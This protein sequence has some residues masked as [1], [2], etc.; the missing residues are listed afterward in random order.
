MS[1]DDFHKCSEFSTPST[2]GEK[3]VDLKKQENKLDR[4]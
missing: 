2:S 4:N 1:K 3:R